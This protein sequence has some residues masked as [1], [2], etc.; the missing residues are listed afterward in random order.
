VLP[1]LVLVHL[2]AAPLLLPLRALSMNLMSGMVDRVDA[3]LPRNE[4]VGERTL[5]V[6]NAP[7]DGAVAYAPLQRAVQG[8]P[9]PRRLRLLASGV[10]EV[11]VSRLDA[12]TLRLRPADGFLRSEGERMM[13]GLSRP[14]RPGDEI[15]LSGLRVR[16]GAVSADGRPEEADFLFDVPLDDPSLLWMQWRGSTLSPYVPPPAGGSHVLPAI[17]IT[18]AP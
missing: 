12:K 2:V 15:V 1:L 16:I 8:T 17:D 10:A 4:R 11:R 18:V 9:R 6:V 3:S 5:V 14:F 7:A 13:R